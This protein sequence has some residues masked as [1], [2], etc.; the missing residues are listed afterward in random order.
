MEVTIIKKQSNISLSQNSLAEIIFLSN[1]QL[2]ED[3]IGKDSESYDVLL[4]DSFLNSQKILPGV[5]YCD[6]LDSKEPSFSAF[7][8]NFRRLVFRVEKED[9]KYQGNSSN[10]TGMTKEIKEGISQ[11]GTDDDV[12][13]I[14]AHGSRSS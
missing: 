12:W 5:L 7:G 2:L 6:I 9:G 1:S 4:D 13:R 14:T 8:F 10:H 3:I 11:C